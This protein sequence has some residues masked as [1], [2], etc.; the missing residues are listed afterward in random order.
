MTNDEL[1]ERIEDLVTHAW[2]SGLMAGNA[3]CPS[4][5]ADIL[6]REVFDE[7]N[8]LLDELEEPSALTRALDGM[9][10]TP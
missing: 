2:A 5:Q 9:W 4:R 8:Q 6:H 3:N 1:R 10:D 7:M